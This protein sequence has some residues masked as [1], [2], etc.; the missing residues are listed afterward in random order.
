[1]AVSNVG[2]LVNQ[3]CRERVIGFLHVSE[4]KKGWTVS[5]SPDF[6]MLF[7]ILQ[8][9]LSTHSIAMLVMQYLWYS[10]SLRNMSFSF[11]YF[12]HFIHVFFADFIAFRF[13]HYADDRF[14]AAFPYQDA[15]GIA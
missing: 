8:V 1:M 11:N 15:A 10:H 6:F 12:D 3:K 7:L 5:S 4:I 2:K 14:G 13:H 9:F